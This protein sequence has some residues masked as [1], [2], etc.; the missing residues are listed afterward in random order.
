MNIVTG[1]PLSLKLIPFSYLF[2]PTLIIPFYCACRYDCRVFV[3]SP[4]SHISSVTFLAQRCFISTLVCISHP[5]LF[6][7]NLV[8]HASSLATR[9]MLLSCSP[10]API[11]KCS[12]AFLLL[13]LRRML[14]LLLEHLARISL[15]LQ[16]LIQS[17]IVALQERGHLV[18]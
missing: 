12:L 3:F 2:Y 16:R 8:Q 11:S 10:H 15:L 4:S 13:F 14:T 7:L 6:F 1:L 9:Q 5:R 17:S 18:S